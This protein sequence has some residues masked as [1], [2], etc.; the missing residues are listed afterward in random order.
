MTDNLPPEMIAA[1][2]RLCECGHELGMHSEHDGDGIPRQW[3]LGPDP[4]AIRLG[5]LPPCRCM[6]L[7]GTTKDEHITVVLDDDE[8]AKW[9]ETAWETACLGDDDGDDDDDEGDD[10]QEEDPR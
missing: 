10:D 6:T 2:A 8:W 7:C 3:C 5:L 1:F 9:G 4:A